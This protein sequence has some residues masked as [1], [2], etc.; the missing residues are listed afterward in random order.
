MS[1]LPLGLRS[2]PSTRL[3]IDSV[4]DRVQGMLPGVLDTLGLLLNRDQRLGARLL[5]DKLGFIKVVLDY[6]RAANELGQEWTPEKFDNLF[7]ACLTYIEFVLDMFPNER[8]RIVTVLRRNFGASL[9]KLQKNS[10]I[11]VDLMG[12]RVEASEPPL[13]PIAV[14]EQ[15]SS[16]IYTKI[17]DG[18]VVL[19]EGHPIHALLRKEAVNET[20]SYLQREL[21]ELTAGLRGSNVDRR[22][23]EKFARLTELVNFKDDAG[24][25]TFGLHVRL[26]SQLTRGI[27]AELSETLALQISSILTHSAYFASQYKDWVEFLQNAQSY[28]SQRVV[29]ND[30][31]N[32]VGDAADLLELQPETVDPRI[33]QSFR[34]ISSLLHGDRADRTNAI[35]AA[36]RGIE[37]ICISAIRYSYEQAASLVQDAGR[38]A[39]PTLVK[40]G[41]FAIV[42]VVLALI[43]S[44]MPVI[45]NAAELNWILENLPKIERIGQILRK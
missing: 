27:E 9:S 37:N 38:T 25:I 26:V 36:V 17:E 2:Q 33:P 43:S 21:D 11:L 31:E 13:E 1:Q 22:Y 45:K 30:I 6:F 20:R 15:R 35:Y 19:D 5:Y 4:R 8:S 7:N 28:P 16:P 44:S 42:G 12:R 3:N 39:R 32:V 14:P 41:A 23:T 40:V 34:L 29:D 18:R 24:A 10:V